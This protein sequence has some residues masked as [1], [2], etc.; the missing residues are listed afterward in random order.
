MKSPIVKLVGAALAAFISVSAASTANAVVINPT[1]T[2][3][4]TISGDASG[5]PTGLLSQNDFFLRT[6][7]DD[8]RW[9]SALEF[10]L[11][12]LLPGMGVLDATLNLRDAGPSYAGR[13]DV[14]GYSGNGVVE[15]SDALETGN[16]VGD[17]E[18]LQSTSH[19]DFSIDVTGL[20]QSLVSANAG[21]VGFLLVSEEESANSRSAVASICSGEGGLG[22][23]PNAPASCFGFGPSLDINANVIANPVPASLPLMLT[24]L[25]VVGFMV[26]RRRRTEAA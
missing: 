6:Y 12:D 21:F 10:D 16:K 24:A 19:Q 7:G 8:R 4:R 22:T 11:S 15:L 5:N 20:L 26:R 14:F 9:R 18:V 1:L 13:I 2:D 25:G 3:D 23:N 17:F